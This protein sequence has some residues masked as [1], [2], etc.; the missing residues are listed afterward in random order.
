M[1]GGPGGMDPCPAAILQIVSDPNA[2]DQGVHIN[3]VSAGV[4]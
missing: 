1:N 4:L 3:D 2:G